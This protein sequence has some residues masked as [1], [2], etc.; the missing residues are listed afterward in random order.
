MASFA[1]GGNRLCRP[2]IRLHANAVPGCKQHA[3]AVCFTPFTSR[4]C[5]TQIQ[6]PTC[7]YQNKKP[8]RKGELF[9]LLVAAGIEP[10]SRNAI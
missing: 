4:P 2:R 5:R 6:F 9:V 7:R 8:T 1:H 3:G 10:A